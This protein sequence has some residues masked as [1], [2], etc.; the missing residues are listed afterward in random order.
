MFEVKILNS[1]LSSQFTHSIKICLFIRS[2]KKWL[3]NLECYPTKGGTYSN[4]FINFNKRWIWS[5]TIKVTYG[6]CA[7]CLYSIFYTPVDKIIS[8]QNIFLISSVSTKFG[9]ISNALEVVCFGLNFV[10]TLHNCITS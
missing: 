4:A 5:F 7:K 1:N 10:R 9:V 3:R 8:D 2:H 6:R